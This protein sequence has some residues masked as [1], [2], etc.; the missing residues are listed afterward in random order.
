MNPPVFRILKSAPAV[1]AFIG[2]N[3]CRCYDS[4]EAPQEPVPKD[5]EPPPAR[6]PF[7]VWLLVS[8]V[9]E[10]N[11]SD[12]PPFDRQTVQIDCYHPD[13]KQIGL[14]A[15]AVRDAME[16]HVHMTQVIGLPRDR[17]SRLFR[18]SMQ[19]DFFNR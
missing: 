4:G 11:L 15:D 2:T 17:N 10:N 6:E 12:P 9:P 7:V 14:L 19:F 18:T 5:G 1:T 13:R 3:P 16:A 8:G